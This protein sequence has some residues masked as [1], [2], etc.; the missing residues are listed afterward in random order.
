MGLRPDMTIGDRLK[1]ARRHAGQTQE[2]L[3][4]HSGVNVDTIRKLEQGQRQSARVST[5]N[6]HHERPPKP[7]RNKSAA[8]CA[9]HL[10]WAFN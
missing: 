1:V 7:N 10:V 8:Y 2:Q 5:M 3:A 4:E 6:A 9:F